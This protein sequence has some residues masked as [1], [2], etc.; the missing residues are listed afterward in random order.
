MAASEPVKAKVIAHRSALQ[1]RYP[2]V[3][4]LESDI[5]SPHSIGEDP[6]YPI[7][8][9]DTDRDQPPRIPFSQGSRIGDRCLVVQRIHDNPLGQASFRIGEDAVHAGLVTITAVSREAT[10]NALITSGEW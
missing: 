9:G 2:A 4:E 7:L 6:A 10:T 1:R 5:R 8:V 3:D